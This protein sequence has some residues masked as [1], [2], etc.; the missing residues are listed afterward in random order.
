MQNVAKAVE[1]E[2][3]KGAGFF[4]LAFNFGELPA[5]YVSNSNRDD[6]IKAM[7]EF[8]ERNEFPNQQYN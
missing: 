4:V 6:I 5:Q 2:L 8:I 7:K 3:P 1:N